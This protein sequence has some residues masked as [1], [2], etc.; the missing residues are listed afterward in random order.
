M[1]NSILT[2]PNLYNYDM[3]KFLSYVWAKPQR[4]NFYSI[5]AA[6]LP[7]HPSQLENC[8]SK[9]Y[10]LEVFEEL[11]A[12][13]T[14]NQAAS[15]VVSNPQNHVELLCTLSLNENCKTQL[16][17]KKAPIQIVE[18]L[19][20]NSS[21]LVKYTSEVMKLFIS[22]FQTT[23]I[24]TSCQD[25]FSLI[26]INVMTS[27][28]E[29][30]PIHHNFFIHSFFFP[31]INAFKGVPLLFVWKHANQYLKQVTEVLKFKPIKSSSNVISFEN[32]FFQPISS[33]DQDSLS[34]TLLFIEKESE[35]VCFRL[36]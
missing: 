9:K 18:L 14:E 12:I 26:L 22:F 17:E 24:D 20:S 34:H 32:S 13:M 36:S 29:F 23:C 27:L 19:K 1:I 21:M 16:L 4:F 11:V 31:L 8:S 2:V 15:S 10:V 28:N 25:E 30:N 6:V 35:K 3:S 7:Y 5:L 33:V